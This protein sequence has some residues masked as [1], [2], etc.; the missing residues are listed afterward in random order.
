[1]GKIDISIIL[2]CYNS[3]KTILEAMQSILNQ[4]Y[5]NFEVIIIDDGSIDNTAFIVSEYIKKLKL[6]NKFILLRQ[7]NKGVSSARNY[8]ISKARGKYI[9]FLDSDDMYHK[10]F[11]IE[12]VN[13]IQKFNVDTAYCCYSRKKSEIFNSKNMTIETNLLDNYNLLKNFMYRVGPCVFTNFL[14]KKSILQDNNILFNEELRYAEDIDFIWRYLINCKDGVFVNYN[15]YW[16]QNN[17]LS[18]MNNISWDITQ[19]IEVVVNI[20]KQL[21]LTKNEFFD[22]YKSYMYDRAIWAILKEF[23]F[24]RDK[25]L[26]RKFIETYDVNKSMKNMM[27]K[28]NH[29][30]IKLSSFIYILNKNLFYIFVRKY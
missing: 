19:T 8:G 9:T 13:G 22:C 2:P 10:D 21:K 24:K 6:G 23:S 5:K 18:A 7:S 29:I 3:E 1:M 25:L 4:T 12:L 17:N 14:Y 27:F 20:E 30:L 16:Y 11:L 28:G 15:L 26:F